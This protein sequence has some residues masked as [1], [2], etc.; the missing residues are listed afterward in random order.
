MRPVNKT[1]NVQWLQCPINHGFFCT[2]TLQRCNIVVYT[3]HLKAS[4]VSQHSVSLCMMEYRTWRH[5]DKTLSTL[6]SK[7]CQ[8]FRKIQYVW[9]YLRW[10]YEAVR[11]ICEFHQ[12][13]VTS[14]ALFSAAADCRGSCSSDSLINASQALQPT[15]LA[16]L[17]NIFTEIATWLECLSCCQQCEKRASNPNL[18]KQGEATT[19]RKIAKDATL[20]EVAWIQ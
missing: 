5:S 3:W 2:A 14:F 10:A 11:I 12:G 15:L 9:D 17:P 16:Q 8:V 7:C 19:I 1:W 20:E 4:V 13:F 6:K 18:S